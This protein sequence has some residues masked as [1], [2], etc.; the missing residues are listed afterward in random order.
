MLTNKIFTSNYENVAAQE[1]DGRLGNKQNKE[2]HVREGVE[3]STPKV[4]L[5]IAD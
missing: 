2:F 1:K 5:Y 4:E 3:I